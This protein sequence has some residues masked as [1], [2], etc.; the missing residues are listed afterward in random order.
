MKVNVYS[1]KGA[2]LQSKVEL[3]KDIFG[4]KPNKTALRQ[5]IRVYQI[6]QRQ[7]TVATKTR[8]EVRGG[9]KKPWPQKGTGRARH[10]SIRSPIW[11]GGGVA[12]GPHPRG[13]GLSIPKKVRDLALRSALSAKAAEG[14]VY[15]VSQFSPKE[16]KTALAAALLKKLSLEKPL[17][18]TPKKDETVVRSFRNIPGTHV[19]EVTSI[20]PYTVVRAKNILLLQ[21]SIDVLKERLKKP[22][23]K[24]VTEEKKVK[25]RKVEKPAK[26]AS[27]PTAR[28]SKK[29]VVKRKKQ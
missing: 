9:G 13:F 3:P 21:E 26:K 24:K 20:N 2:K 10:G 18:V 22:V 12:H 5:Y 16:P 4:I 1:E 27:K 7:G 17:V 23:K 28:A 15:V 11:V 25:A 29:K 6:N 8:G 19:E 14:Q